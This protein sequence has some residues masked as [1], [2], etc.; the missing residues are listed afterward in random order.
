MDGSSR[1]V[2]LGASLAGGTAAETLRSEGFDGKV[3]LV[4][5]EPER[6]YERP[7]L[8]KE[9]LR[10]ES[11][12]EDVFL[13]T[14]AYYEK[15]GIELRLGQRARALHA[16]EKLI[17]LD[18][19]YKIGY[20]KLLI[21]TGTSP[22]QLRVP[23]ADLE[24]IFYLRTL[25]DSDALGEALK[26]GP[27]VLV[28]GAGFIGSEVAASAR[29]T[30]CAVTMLEVAAVPLVRA[31]GE[32][33][34]AIYADFHRERGV[35]VRTGEMVTEFRGSDRL[36]AAV[37]S[38]GEVIPC[39][40]A[41]IGVGVAPAVDFLQGSGIEIDNGVLTDEMC[42]TN[43]PDIF[44]A[45][46]VASWWHPTWRERLRLEHYDN[47][48]NQGVAAAKS[49][50]GIG[51][52]YAPIPY[53]WSDQY[54]LNLQYRGYASRWDEIAVRGNPAEHSFSAFYLLGGRLRA[55]LSVNR[56]PDQLAATQLI[57]AAS[58][59]DARQLSDEGVE[60]E[61]LLQSQH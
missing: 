9:Y 29:S 42:R 60:L 57:S 55:C 53:F 15:Q 40:V 23:G 43:I 19:G 3:I 21:T 61:Q 28:V 6:P 25:P 14:P 50:L 17:E 24:G 16:T 58:R 31:L 39:D 54:D 36:E 1:Y 59:V 45:G 38:S 2:I 30:G 35:N 47:A 26:K 48:L 10:R 13:N 22:R 7:P 18:S 56:F 32:Q 44:A 8:S 12:R 49:M 46:D 27:H 5:A 51:E 34:G 4:G 11:P 41:V 52:P 37:T 33:V 20:E